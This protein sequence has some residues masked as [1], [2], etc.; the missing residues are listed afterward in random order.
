MSDLGFEFDASQHEDTG[1]DF[2]PL[3]AGDYAV[4]ITKVEIKETNA[5]D[6]RYLSLQLTVTGPTQAGRV[7]FDMIALSTTS[8]ESGKKKWVEI[9]QG[10]LSGLCR[11]V[12]LQ[13]VKDSQ[14]FVGRSATAKVKVKAASGDYDAS[15]EIKAYK[16][17]AGAIPAGAIPVGASAAPSKPDWMG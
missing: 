16:P 9:G 10:K 4:D 12:G 5:N 6:G 11:A 13:K 2:A 8:Q 1:G 3:P 15:N 14:V 17:A 7:L